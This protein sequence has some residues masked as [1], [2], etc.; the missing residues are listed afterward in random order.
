M[1]NAPSK[2]GDYVSGWCYGGVQEESL[3]ETGVLRFCQ[4]SGCETLDCLPPQFQF[5]GDVDYT[6]NGGQL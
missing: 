2:H 3:Y 6:K 1:W 4:S 5:K